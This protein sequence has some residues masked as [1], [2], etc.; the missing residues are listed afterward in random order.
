MLGH[1][2]GHLVVCLERNTAKGTSEKLF[3]GSMT[4][5]NLMGW[6]CKQQLEVP[7]GQGLCVILIFALLLVVFQS[8]S[9]NYWI[10]DGLIDSSQ[11]RSVH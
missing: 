9:T 6:H 8:V 10:W 4:C 3:V 5:P 2:K 7:L 1:S 11:I